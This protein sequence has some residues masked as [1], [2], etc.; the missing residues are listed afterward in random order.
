MFREVWDEEVSKIYETILGQCI[1]FCD[2]TAG[3]PVFLD[4]PEP[5]FG[6]PQKVDAYAHL[7][8]TKKYIM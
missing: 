8:E 5:R 1:Y 2:V 6:R 3:K 4:T 7:K